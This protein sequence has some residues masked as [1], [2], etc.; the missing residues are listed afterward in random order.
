MKNWNGRWPDGNEKSDAM[1][2]A[3]ALNNLMT[4]RNPFQVIVGD[5][6]HMVQVLAGLGKTR[7][8][9]MQRIQQL[10]KQVA[11]VEQQIADG[12]SQ[13]YGHRLNKLR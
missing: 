5:L 6:Q 9:A 1:L 2:Y 13:P 10:E 8:I 12:S 4:E 3:S 7:K 11:S